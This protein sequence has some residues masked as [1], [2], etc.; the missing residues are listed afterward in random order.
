MSYQVIARKWR[1]QQFSE[2]TGQEA[3]T[4]TLQN[5]IR[6]ERLHHAY[7]FS[8]SRGCGKTTTARILAKAINCIKGITPEPCSECASCLEISSGSSIDVLEIDAASNTGVD[9]I[10]DLIINTIAINPARDRAKVFIIDEVHMLSISA[11]NALL[12]TL[13][14]PPPHAVFILATTE[15]HKVP[16]TIVSRCQQFEFRTIAAESIV[17]RLRLIADAEQ[18]TITNKALFEIALA[19][20]GSMRDAQSAFDQVISFAGSSV[21]DDDVA[22]AL[23]II[24]QQTI[25]N[26]TVAIADAD[27]KAIIS[28]VAELAASGYDLR[29]FSRDLMSHFRNLL[30]LKTVGYDKELISIIESEVDKYQALADKFSAEDLIRFFN[31]L[32]EIEQDMRLSVQPKF[33]LEI[34]LLKLAHFTRLASI[35]EILERLAQ[36][37]EKIRSGGTEPLSS[38]SITRP[39]LKNRPTPPPTTKKASEIATPTVTK[40][41]EPPST[42]EQFREVKIAE[43]VEF[44]EPPPDREYEQDL[45]VVDSRAFSAQAD[46]TVSVTP[47]LEGLLAQIASEMERRGASPLLIIALEKA[48]EAKLEESLLTLRYEEKSSESYNKVKNNFNLVLETVRQLFGSST[49]LNLLLGQASFSNT[50]TAKETRRASAVTTNPTDDM[51]QKAESDATV[52]LILKKFKGSLTQVNKRVDNQ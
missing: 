10:R 27:K 22:K 16:Q 6:L 37:E 9:N 33:Q 5:A 8:G 17:K 2:V 43:V 32:T 24:N 15:L 40:N 11:F 21:K 13:E 28:L 29:Q 49:K 48:L 47:S 38:P 14:E 7:L 20:Q 35:D 46:S 25:L 41:S 3:I 26:F 12:K 30:I 23:G 51:R 52:Q 50:D 1:P 4:R 44:V 31:T 34:G 39:T 42:M 19:G 45:E 18:I 36:L